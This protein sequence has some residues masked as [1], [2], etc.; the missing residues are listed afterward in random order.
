MLLF[1]DILHKGELY[2]D[3]EGIEF[4]SFEQAHDYLAQSGSSSGL[5]VTHMP[6]TGLRR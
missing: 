6:S 2:L 5:V 1:F 4:T 3:V